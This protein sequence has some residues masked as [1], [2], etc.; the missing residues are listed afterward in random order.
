MSL[1]SSTSPTI[2]DGFYNYQN[3]YI[4]VG[5]SFKYD[6]GRRNHG[7][8]GQYMNITITNYY[9]YN[10]ASN[11]Y[12]LHYDEP[13]IN[14]KAIKN[15]KLSL[16]SSESSEYSFSFSKSVSLEIASF[17]SSSLSFKNFK[18][19]NESSIT[20]STTSSTTYSYSF[21]NTK[22]ITKEYEFDYTLVPNGYVVSP[23]IVCNAIELNFTYTIYDQYWW[24]DYVSQD[25][26][27]VNVKNSLLIYDGS[28][29]FI[30]LCIK[31]SGVSGKPT[32][33][34]NA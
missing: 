9:S 14:P 28:T 26:S 24:G 29:E 11:G 32:L 2:H 31:E 1:Y 23:C 13:M 7:L 5:N 30:T 25:S 12:I 3:K 16:S 6:L 17:L 19:G 34:L 4:R 10:A 15:Q 27:E 20:T 33:Y 22:T 8:I 21:G 18:I